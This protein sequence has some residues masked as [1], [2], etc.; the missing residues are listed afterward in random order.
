MLAED[1]RGVGFVGDG[2]RVEFAAQRFDLRDWSDMAVHTKEGIGQDIGHTEAVSKIRQQL[3]EGLGIAMRKD[4]DGGFGK[5]AAV[6]Q[7][8]VV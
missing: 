8:G 5:S 7:A 2:N 4:L 3:A 1:A 6:D